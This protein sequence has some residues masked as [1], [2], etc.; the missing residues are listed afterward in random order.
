MNFFYRMRTMHV[1]SDITPI[2]KSKTDDAMKIT[3]IFH[4][5]LKK[6]NND[7][8]ET[9]LKIPDRMMVGELLP[10]INVPKEEIAFIAV[11]GSRASVSQIIQDGDKVKLFQMVGGG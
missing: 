5:S 7:F 8:V 9:E 11:N 6:Y 2:D 3:L 4:G 1:I 10:K